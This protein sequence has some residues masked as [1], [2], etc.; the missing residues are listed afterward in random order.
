MSGRMTPSAPG[1]TTR[2]RLPFAARATSRTPGARR[3]RVNRRRRCHH[4]GN[5]HTRCGSRR[6]HVRDR[7]LR[8]R[9]DRKVDRR[10]DCR[11]RRKARASE[12]RAMAGI[13]GVERSLVATDQHVLVHGAPDRTA[14]LRRTH[15]R[16]RRG[17]QQR[18][19]VVVQG[20]RVLS[21]DATCERDTQRMVVEFTTVTRVRAKDRDRSRRPGRCDD[22]H[23][24]GARKSLPFIATDSN[25]G[26]LARPCDQDCRAHPD[27]RCKGP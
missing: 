1:P 11:E 21:D 4:D 5:L 27:R 20:R 24:N 6:E 2:T 8:R 25:A 9:N 22:A 23:Y 15:E 26:S 14:P 10:L 18:A 12:H 17:L 13:H 7:F 16:N 3:R 19:K